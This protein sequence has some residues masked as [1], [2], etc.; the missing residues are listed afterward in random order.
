MLYSTEVNRALQRPSST[1]T[2]YS[3]DHLASKG[4]DGNANTNYHS[5]ITDA[6]KWLRVDL[7]ANYE[8]SRIEI[9]HNFGKF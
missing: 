4:V 8:I 9:I 3:P 5:G 1:N 7:G 6:P 2:E